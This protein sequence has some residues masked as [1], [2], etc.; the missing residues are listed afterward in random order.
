MNGTW[1]NATQNSEPISPDIK[2]S[3]V[4][5]GPTAAL[6][7]DGVSVFSEEEDLL[8]VFGVNMTSDKWFN[9]SCQYLV[10]HENFIKDVLEP[11]IIG[12]G[13]C[14]I[15]L[16][17][18]VLTRKC[19]INSCNCYLTALAIGDLIF[20]L[21]LTTRN[22]FEKFVDCDLR[23]RFELSTWDTYSYIVMDIFQYFAVGVT[24]MLAVERYIA[25]C[26]PMRTMG[27][28]TVKR[29]RIIIVLLAFVSLVLMF[30]KFF[31]MQPTL[32][33]K[34]H[35]TFLVMT[36]AYVYDNQLYSY[37]A[38]FTLLTIVPLVSL[39][40]L[41]GRII[42]EIHRSSRYLQNYLGVDWRVRSIVS[43]E[44]LKITMMLVTVVLAFFVC[45]APYMV[46]TAA[47]AFREFDSVLNAS[48]LMKYLRHICHSLMALKSVCNFIL[49]CWFSDKFWATF[50]RMFCKQKCRGKKLSYRHGSCNNG[51]HCRFSSRTHPLRSS[52]Y[53]SKETTC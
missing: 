26:H 18:T 43:S 38:T 20:L 49:Y 22:L 14:G 48:D 45:H 2:T 8:P 23:K 36:F 40:V 25:I 17:L 27:M 15:L 21:I 10:I 30:P 1:F 29:A 42:Y 4:A 5:I 39:M 37:I 11:M 47:T 34:G 12:I 33:K 53:V 32:A 7:K 16:T 28:C 13:V 31:D 24:V 41:N 19:M 46:Y 51:H 50:K 44:E 9:E 52:D 3:G 6:A 35:E